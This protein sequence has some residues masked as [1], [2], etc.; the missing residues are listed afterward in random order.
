MIP[1]GE[2][3]FAPLDTPLP[4]AVSIPSDWVKLGTVAESFTALGK[5]AANASDAIFEF[6][7]ATKPITYQLKGTMSPE[8]HRL[9]FGG[10]QPKR[11]RKRY[12]RAQTQLRKSRR[13][14]RRAT[15]RRAIGKRT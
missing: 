3:F 5:A 15:Q 8:I 7:E 13:L 4:V 11:W 9:F 1:A 6:S 14:E 10:K 12:D 2:V